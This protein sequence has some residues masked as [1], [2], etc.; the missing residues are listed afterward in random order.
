MQSV[1]T[2]TRDVGLG[3]LTAYFLKLGAIG[4]GGPVALVGFMYRGTRVM[5]P[6]ARRRS[7]LIGRRRSAA[8]R[9]NLCS[10]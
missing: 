5:A 4:F 7:E 8:M 9:S 3:R 2:S 6:G 1:R 10:H